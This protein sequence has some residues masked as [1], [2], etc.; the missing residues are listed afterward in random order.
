MQEGEARLST[1]LRC[2]PGLRGP[3]TWLGEALGCTP[4][5][6]MGL[7][8]LGLL[9]DNLGKILGRARAPALWRPRHPRKPDLAPRHLVPRPGSF[10]RPALPLPRSVGGCV[11][12]KGHRKLP[13]WWV[14]MDPAG[15][16]GALS[17]RRPSPGTFPCLGPGPPWCS[18]EVYSSSPFSYWPMGTECEAPSG[19]WEE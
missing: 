3:L 14:G 17:S 12:G 15:G 19:A 1:P 16:C 10:E 9:G 18:E 13:P 4:F 6:G 7:C 5:S 8:G 2:W 11:G